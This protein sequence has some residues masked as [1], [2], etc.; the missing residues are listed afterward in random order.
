MHLSAPYSSVIP[1]STG[2]VLGVLAGTIRQLTGREITRLSGVPRSTAARILQHLVEHGLV[3]AQEAGPALLY[4]LNRE[5]QA[6]QPVLALLDLRSR[7]VK[8]L[9]SEL[10][11]WALPPVHMSMFGSAARGDGDTGSDV[12]L[13]IVRPTVVDADDEVWQEQI[14][15]ISRLIRN[16]TGNNAGITEV[17]ESDL[18]RLRHERPPVIGE[19]ERDAITLLGPHPRELFQESAQ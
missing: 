9:K 19:V 4:H 13:L 15:R 17:V 18:E 12:D 7:L 11:C 14:D 8:G 6:S 10:E 1:E 3:H 5:H 16:W 2:R